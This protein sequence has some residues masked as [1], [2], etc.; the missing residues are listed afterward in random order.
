MRRESVVLHSLAVGESTLLAY[1]HYGRPVLVFPSD[2]GRAWD[3]ENLGM[4]DGITDLLEGGRVKLYCVDSYDNASW[5]RND[6]PLEARAQAHA[7]FE[8]FVLQDVLPLIYDDCQGPTP[9]MVTGCSFGAFHA[10][11]VALR[12]ADAFPVAL[13]MSGVYDMSRIGWGERGD[14]FYFNNP[15]DYVAN[16][17]GDHLDWIRGHV[18]LQLVCGQGP[19]EDDS[20][21][22]A[23]PSTQRFAGLLAEKGVPHNLDL[24]GYD[25]AHDWGSW[26]AQLAHHLPRFL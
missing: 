4:L 14:A 1:G 5:R 23:L 7:K 12:R 16:F 15:T 24:W 17:S 25:V 26:R 6:L 21:S 19:W 10:A 8:D 22:G 20:A 18:F 13:C 9:V 2:G 11:N 3:W